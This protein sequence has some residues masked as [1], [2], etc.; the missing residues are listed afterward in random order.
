MILQAINK[1]QTFSDLINQ[2]NSMVTAVLHDSLKRSINI[3]PS[4]CIFGP[5]KQGEDVEMTISV[6]NEDS[7]CQRIH[8]KPSQDKR[9]VVKQET[10]GPIAPGMTRKLIVTLLA[11]N[12]DKETLGKIKEEIHIVTK[13]DIFKLNIEAEILSSD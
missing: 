5:I 6:K 13:S 10:Y 3:L 7:L 4:V 11:S 12:K 1:K 8:I 2:A 9:L